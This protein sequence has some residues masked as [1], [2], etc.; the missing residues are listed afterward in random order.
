MKN[1]D[2]QNILSS[3]KIIYSNSS[4]PVIFC[5]KNVNFLWGNSQSEK[6]L[7]KVNLELILSQEDANKI[8]NS[9][10][11]N[12]NVAINACFLPFLGCKI[13]VLSVKYGNFIG[14][15]LV[16]DISEGSDMEYIFNNTD[17]IV[18]ILSSNLRLP[19]HLITNAIEIL[20]YDIDKMFPEDPENKNKIKKTIC[21]VE[22]NTYKMYRVCKNLSELIRFSTNTNPFNKSVVRISHYINNLIDSCS[23]WIRLYGLNV[24][25][26]FSSLVADSPSWM[27]IDCEKIS[28]AISN[29]LLN[30]CQ[31]S[32]KN[33][34]IFINTTILKDSISITIK[35]QGFGISKDKL[36]DIFRPYTAL[37]NKHY[38]NKG[39]GI[40]LTLSK[41]IINQHDG[42]IFIESEEGIGTTI[43]VSIPIVCDNSSNVIK[44]NTGISFKSKMS[45]VSI[46]FSPLY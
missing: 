23:D 7:E 12:S 18:S 33:K 16:F 44:V 19:I 1:N 22:N 41:Y 42:T 11:K 17:Y 2:L 32:N 15:V 43:F 36:C 21:V 27:S 6:V 9:I 31:Y 24:V 29:I 34:S 5:D 40:G 25:Y 13:N 28:L 39:M 37:E 38:V 35:D 26:N 4:A 46:Q 8:K 10:L 20:N 45:I 30:C 14:A 3:I